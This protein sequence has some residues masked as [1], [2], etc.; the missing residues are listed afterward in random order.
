MARAFRR[1]RVRGNGR[2]PRNPPPPPQDHSGK[3]TCELCGVEFEFAPVYEADA[4]ETL[5]WH[6]LAAAGARFAASTAAPF[7][8]RVG[9][10]AALWL[11]VTPLATCMLYRSWIHR[12]SELPFAWT[13]ARLGEE[14]SSGLAIVVA[15]VVSFL[16][17][18]SFTDYMRVRWE[19]LEME[20]GDD[21]PGPVEDDAAPADDTDDGGDDDDD[22]LPGDSD[23]ESDGDD[24]DDGA[25]DGGDDA[26]PRDDDDDEIELHIAMDE[27]LGLRGPLVN[28]TR[29]VSWL[30]V[31]N[32]AYLGIFAFAPFAVGSLVGRV[33]GGRGGEHG[34]GDGDAPG[35][36]ERLR[37]LAAAGAAGVG[38]AARA[39]GPRCAALARA[40]WAAGA[41]PWA[42]E[43]RDDARSL[44]RAG[45]D[46]L[47]KRVAEPLAAALSDAAAAAARSRE[48]SFFG[49]HDAPPPPPTLRFEDLR[50]ICVGYVALGFAACLWREALRAAPRALRR[51]APPRALRRAERT[52]D[53]AAA[54]A[55]VA[56][57]L[58]LKMALLPTLLGAGLDAA[59][60]VP[61]LGA[62]P[63]STRGAFRWRGS[64][65]DVVVDGDVDG[66]EVVQRSWGAADAARLC[67]GGEVGAALAR[68]VLGITFMLVVTVAVLQLRE[69]LHPDLLAKFVRPH[70]PRPDLLATL[71]GESAA[72]HGR[73]LATSLG[74][75]GALLGVLVAAPACLLAAPLRALDLAPFAPRLRYAAPAA[76]I[77]LEL[78]L[79]HLGLLTL[80][81]RLKARVGDAQG[82]FLARVCRRLG[83]EAHLL[84]TY[85]G[86]APPVAAAQDRW[87]W[88]DEPK[89]PRE[90]KVLPR[91][92]L[93]ASAWPRLLAAFLLC[94]VAVVVFYGSVAALP[95]VFGRWLLRVARAPPALRHDPLA[96]AC[97]WAAG[98][99]FAGPALDGGLRVAEGLEKPPAGATLR[100]AALWFVAAPLGVGVLY[101][102]LVVADGAPGWRV[103]WANDWLFGVVFLH[104]L[105]LAASRVA[106]RDDDDDDGDGAARPRSWAGAA[107]DA[108]TRLEAAVVA[109]DVAF[110]D[111]AAV[112]D[113]VAWPV[114]ADLLGF[115]GAP[116]VVAAAAVAARASADGEAVDGRQILALYRWL[117]ALGGSAALAGQLVEPLRQWLGAARAA[118]RDA[119]YLVGL[120]LQNYGRG[121]GVA[122]D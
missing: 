26:E 8:A 25:S 5:P 118:V 103:D 24:D 20:R 29:N 120:K 74:I 22:S 96:L 54:A 52:L 102:A 48:V 70:E 121:A 35:R 109:R 1:V 104:A 23:G 4:P 79:F 7:A 50:K 51:R 84:P 101:D 17:L 91:R 21:A 83:L 92:A 39:L 64:G 73:R 88:G 72:L 77:P 99:F 42:R 89:A 85:A 94:W 67:G 37:S 27:L 60:A 61:L 44:A 82:W 71:L 114:V 30:I 80:L 66:A 33:A 3:D 62:A 40:A 78:L 31:F 93:D 41:A 10:S 90:A 98:L 15:I 113:D 38:D 55:K 47:R 106:S 59:T 63:E 117:L 34:V 36:A 122:A 14:L 75:Y 13:S 86:R 115:A 18:L 81:E 28:V 65:G 11:G 9:A 49:D 53:A 76:Q 43:G 108:R 119:K 6:A 110:V 112:A 100:C 12:P 46:A 19:I 57:V 111:C 58:F 32:A 97:G 45:Y 2:K 68:W 107:L 95:L 69:V 87:A 116:L 105:A 56:A 16:S